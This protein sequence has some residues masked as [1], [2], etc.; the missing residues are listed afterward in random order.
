MADSIAAEEV[1]QFTYQGYAFACRILECPEPVTEPIVVMCAAFQN[2]RS[3]HRYDKFWRDSATIICMEP[4]G[5]YSPDPVPRTVGYGFDADALAYL[6]D[7][8]DLSRIN[9]LGISLGAAPTHRFAQEYPE[10]VARLMLTGAALGDTAR[11]G[12]AELEH[13]L[14]LRRADVFGHKMVELCVNGDPTRTVR[15]RVAVRRALL[16][17][18]S[19]ASEAEL[20]R[21]LAVAQRLADHPATL[22]GRISGI[23][24]LCV[25]GEHDELAPPDLT[26]TM[27]AGID[28]AAFTTMRET[29]HVSFLERHAD[30]ADLVLRFFTDQPLADL[31]Y[32]TGL[33]HP[34][35]R[36][37]HDESAS[38]VW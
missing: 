18:L 2:I 33:E 19:S 3:Y 29:C 17:H 5:S 8:L 37:G 14:S 26:R 20:V 32:L 25:T 1:R 38:S 11:R 35:G 21:Y 4:P 31:D 23:P 7:E 6:L 36:P 13:W 16:D 12:A 24:A 27:A 15:N 28:G 22:P 30:W 9:L 10:R 34:A